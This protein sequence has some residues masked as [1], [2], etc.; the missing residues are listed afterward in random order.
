MTRIAIFALPGC[1]A[2]EHYV[3]RFQ[4]IVGRYRRHVAY[5]IV[6]GGTVQGNALAIK[7]RIRAFPT[8]IIFY[9]DGRESR[10][11]GA[12]ADADIISMLDRAAAAAA[13][14]AA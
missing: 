12:M 3:P 14:R 7:F 6:D 10:K 4:R 1:P 2:C 9:E 5:K 11:V 8:T 13:R